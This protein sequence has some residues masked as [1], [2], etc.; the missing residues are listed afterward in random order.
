[1]SDFSEEE[2]G[3]FPV[4]KYRGMCVEDVRRADAGYVQWLVRQPWFSARFGHL[5][6]NLLSQT[7][8]VTSPPN[9]ARNRMQNLFLRPEFLQQLAWKLLPDHRRSGL[10]NCQAAA[11]GFAMATGRMHKKLN[12]T[13]HGTG[14]IKVEYGWECNNKSSGKGFYG[15][16]AAYDRKVLVL[17]QEQ[18]TECSVTQFEPGDGFDVCID[19]AALVPAMSYDFPF[20]DA[21]ERE[22]VREWEVA[23]GLALVTEWPDV[24]GKWYVLLRPLLGDDYPT[25]LRRTHERPGDAR[26]IVVLVGRY[27]RDDVTSRDELQC[28]FAHGGA[29]IVFLDEL[30]PRFWAYWS[31]AVPLPMDEAT[32]ADRAHASST[33]YTA[34]ASRVPFH[35]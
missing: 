33:T 27:D 7:P 28:L 5:A 35:T 23:H 4:G 34:T 30:D 10:V 21:V 17:Y 24:R 11:D 29:R 8:N 32:T 13:N 26:G 2:A 19:I 31:G 22:A 25:L 18:V 16:Y 14:T 9:P 12:Q 3:V 15:G 20:A 6:T 1:M